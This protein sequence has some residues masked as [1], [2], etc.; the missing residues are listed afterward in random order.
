LART[1]AKDYDNKRAAILSAAARVFADGGY[2]R[3]SMATLAGECG[4]SK[5]LLYHYYAS[6][7]ALL[8]DILCSHL[9]ALAAA[10]EDA[11]AGPPEARLRA[12]ISALLEAYRDADAEHRLQ[13]N[14][15]GALPEEAQAELR[16]LLRRLVERFAEAVKAANPALAESPRLKPATMALFGMLNWYYMWGREGGPVSRE[17]YADMVATLFLDGVRAVK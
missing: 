3:T 12:L 1:R 8:H 17:D 6:K 11:P 9:E 2:D 16:A 13:A 15:L 10:V 14:A 4:V 7:E 5:A